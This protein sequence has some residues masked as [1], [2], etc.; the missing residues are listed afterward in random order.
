[1]KLLKR[2]FLALVSLLLL[3]LVVA[4]FVKSEFAVEREILIRKPR[5]E[6][7]GYI[8]M[9]QNQNDY[10][11]WNLRDPNSKRTYTG[12]DGKV[13]FVYS[14]ESEN[15][16]VGM[17]EQE[18]KNLVEGERIDMELRFKKPFESTD[19]AYMTTTDAPEGKTLVK[20]GF[21]GEMNY[22]MNLM[23]LFMD[24]DKMLGS[25]LQEGLNNLKK[26]LETD[27]AD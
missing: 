26:I 16:E 8:K 11:V 18:I 4:A 9:V 22:P 2:I 21:S 19:Q 7:F 10:S 1:M 25:Q 14:W 12:T 17:G 15:K 13:G 3:A 24:M 23:L 20:W 5:V 27:T 6:V